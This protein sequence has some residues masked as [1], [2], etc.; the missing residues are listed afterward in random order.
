MPRKKSF[1]RLLAAGLLIA[2]LL[3]QAQAEIYLDAE[4]PA[5]WEGRDNLMRV[6]AFA[7]QLNDCT[8]I[9]VGGKSMLVDGGVRKWRTQLVAALAELGYDGRVDILFNT[10]PH[11]DHLQAVTY[12][13]NEG[14][15][16]DEF[17]SSFPTTY[18]NDY[19]KA[20]VKALENAEIPY[21]QLPQ[22]ETVDFGGATLVF[23]WWEDG[24]DPNARSCLMHV[25]YQDA[26]IL[27]TADATGATQNGL[28]KIIDPVYLQ[29][30]V[31]KLPHHGIVPCVGDFLKA[32]DPGFI[33]ITNRKSA[34]P[35]AITQLENAKIPFYSTSL[36]RVVMVTDGTDWY[37]KQYRDMF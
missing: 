22:M 35:K 28:L 16:A 3:S 36:G 4:P 31:M 25:T 37:I 26:T 19:Q 1:L 27:M 30:D 10:H 12:M 13:I 11:D 20:V 23:Y 32:V 7:T 5:D 14:F 21:H 15:R 8:L 6:T 18:R 17:W 33:F 29:A 9:E 2:L 34:I 24:K